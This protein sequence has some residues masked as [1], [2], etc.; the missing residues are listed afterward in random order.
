MKDAE[1]Y[2]A[3]FFE[4][5]R[6]MSSK[7]ANAAAPKILELYPARSVIDV[8]CGTGAWV[9]AFTDC[10]IKRAIGI[11]GDYVDRNQLMVASSQFISCDLSQRVDAAE[12]FR[13]LGTSERF[14]LAITL[15]VGEHLP[16]WRAESFVDDMCMLADVVLFGAAIPF[17]G[18]AKSHINEQ[19]QSFWAKK[20]CDRGYDAFDVF[21]PAIWSSSE[22][23]YFYKQNTIFYVKRNA[24]A[25]AEF[26]ARYHKPTTSMF[27]IVHPEHYRGKVSRL[28]NGYV[29][30]KA[31]NFFRLSGGARRSTVLSTEI[32]GDEHW[33]GRADRP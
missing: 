25:H 29:A 32:Q 21:R 30:Q 6:G 3:K 15:E 13:Q 20:F 12:I 16:V 2:S 9:K 8:G 19:W 26:V 14:D 10:G 31:L 5:I 4:H 28:K 17:Q 11:D 23:V 24:P 22:I 7:S 1:Q 33:T 18:W 27:D